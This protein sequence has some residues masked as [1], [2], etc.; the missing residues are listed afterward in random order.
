MMLAVGYRDKLVLAA[1]THRA[2]EPRFGIAGEVI[3]FERRQDKGEVEV[4]AEHGHHE[5]NE[6]GSE[7]VDGIVRRT[8]AVSK[9]LHSSS[10][11]RYMRS[12]RNT[13]WTL[14]DSVSGMSSLRG[15]RF[16]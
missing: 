10:L 12:L 7:A 6:H 13:S 14:I 1:L 3:A 9:Y 8:S 11:L 5:R 4:D 16:T 2:E 15:I